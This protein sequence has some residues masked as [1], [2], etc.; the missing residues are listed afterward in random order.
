MQTLISPE[1][2]PA[3]APPVAATP[4]GTVAGRARRP[5][6]VLWPEDGIITVLLLCL[7]V[8]IT[9]ASIQAVNP[10]WAPGMS[11]LTPMTLVGLLMGLIAV[12]QRAVPVIV[13]HLVAVVIGCVLAFWQTA[14]A[15]LA[16][17]RGVLWVHLGIWL[18]RALHNKT[19]DDFT[20]FLLF[21]AVLSYLLAYLSFW[22]VIHS[23]RPW[24]AVLACGVVLLINLDFANPDELIFLVLFLL[25]ALLL[26][27]R[28]TLAENMRLWRFR[29][30]RFSPDLS[31][32]FL[33][34]GAIFAV[35]VLLLAYMLPV[36]A[37]NAA[38]N[39]FWSNPKGAWQAIQS[40]WTGLFGNLNGPGGGGS[41]SFFSSE[42]Q[43]RGNVN[44]PNVEIFRYVSNDPTQYLATQTYDTY[45]GHL[46][47]TNS[48]TQAQDFA[49]DAV[50]PAP[51]AAETTINQTVY[52]TNISDGQRSLFAAGEPASFSIPSEVSETTV[53]NMPTAWYAQR[54][55]VTGDTYMA[56]SYIS[57]A[58]VDQL[59]AVVPPANA[60]VGTY[61]QYVLDRDLNN[62]N[63]IISD[64]VKT[65]AQQWAAGAA[66]PYD[67]MVALETHLHDFTYSTQNGDV[68]SDQDAV[69]WFLRNK[70]G[71]CTFFASTMA[72]MARSLGMPARIVSGVSTGEFDPS[73]RNY[74]V[75]GL[76]LHVWTQVYFA[77]YGWI[78]FE[79]TAS[80]NVFQRGSGAGAPGAGATAAAQ[81]T[82]GAGGR[83][84]ATPRGPKLIG[85]DT[86]NS[87]PS[88]TTTALRDIGLTIA[89]LVALLLLLV[90]AFVVWW[91]ALYR[92]LPPIGAAFA[93]MSR[94]G[95]WSG[96]PP[97]RDQTP[98]EYANALGQV[99]PEEEP[100]LS[101]LSD[102][103]VLDRWGGVAAP[104]AE[105]RSLYQRL[106]LALA[107]AILNRWHELPAFL[108]ARL[109]GTRARFGALGA[110]LGKRLHWVS[111][112]FDPPAY[113]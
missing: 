113:G 38:I 104:A 85:P 27:V 10:P 99:V 86:G 80:Y 19:N 63:T 79:P 101:R 46:A 112:L 14:G 77:G 59:R 53:G 4:E 24:L 107:R 60:S 33:Q 69:V 44:L 32:D 97:R 82:T 61:P 37:P 28:F 76:Q 93:R 102:L 21:L 56:Q 7:A 47:W 42:L 11:I 66:T 34:A 22:L 70:K 75:K 95:T 94:L 91:R 100:T 98:Y 84:T 8:Y 5:L 71:F 90:A 1:T 29:R 40:R 36:G 109:G 83:A 17:D 110:S 103:Y 31:W 58:T 108:L 25:V 50:F 64:P 52:L 105:A 67:Q 89:F 87:A 23:R 30:L 35:V 3:P 96:S 78:N 72:L 62:D 57:N 26:L 2:S 6:F 88:A 68:P 45:D 9:I 51:S 73:Q 13:V 74:V 111:R 65:T 48:L 15:V 12:Q 43:L 81:G 16:G 92:G 49:A 20:I 39:A 106:R 18:Q 55:L 41:V 54:G